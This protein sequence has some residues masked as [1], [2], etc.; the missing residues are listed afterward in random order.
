[1]IVVDFVYVTSLVIGLRSAVM[2]S[3]WLNLSSWYPQTEVQ[4]LDILLEPAMGLKFEGVYKLSCLSSL[5]AATGF[6]RVIASGIRQNLKGVLLALTNG[7]PAHYTK[8]G[9]YFRRGYCVAQGPCQG[10]LGSK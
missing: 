8:W 6:H 1:M 9:T 7:E 4:G 10:G 3:L 5:R 2:N